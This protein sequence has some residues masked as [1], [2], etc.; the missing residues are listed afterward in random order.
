MSSLIFRMLS[1]KYGG[2]SCSS[3]P[4]TSSSM[5]TLLLFVLLLLVST[6]AFASIPFPTMISSALL[7][8]TSSMFDLTKA[9]PSL[10]QCGAHPCGWVHYTSQG[11]VWTASAT[12]P[13]RTTHSVIHVYHC[14][15][16]AA[17]G[18]FPG[19][20]AMRQHI[21]WAPVQDPLS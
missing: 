19:R 2:G 11:G 20:L 9:A 8:A 6:T 10:Q 4:S 18:P 13:A 15:D 7:V 17:G 14:I 3:S 16:G 1:L 5:R 12:Q 21:P